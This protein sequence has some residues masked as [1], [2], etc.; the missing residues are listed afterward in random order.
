MYPEVPIALRLSGQ[1][2]LGV[3]RIYS[4]Q[5]D[6]LYHDCNTALAGMSKSYSSVNINLP[7]DAT[8]APYHAVTLPETF[9]LDALELEDDHHYGY[10]D[11]HRK[12]LEDITLEDQIPTGTDPYIVITLN[13]VVRKDSSVLG[14]ALETD[15]VPMEEDSHPSLPLDGTANISPDNQ[16]GAH[17]KTIEVGTSQDLPEIEI[18]RDAAHD[19]QIDSNRTWP[20]QGYDA[21]EPDRVLEELI[22]KD[23]EAISPHAGEILA[24]GQSSVPAHQP[25][26]PSPIPSEHTHESLDLPISLRLNSPELA[27]RSTPPAEQPRAR[28]RRRR[29]QPFDKTTVLSNEF[30]N[31]SRENRSNILRKKRN[32]SST[33]L[34]LM[35]DIRLKRDP[36]FHNPLI[37]GLSSELQSICD[38]QFISS[39]T[40]LLFSD[41]IHQDADVPRSPPLRDNT[42]MEIEHLRNYEVPEMHA[43]GSVIQPSSPPN[44]FNPSP[45]RGDKSTPATF[46]FGSHSGLVETNI[47]SE[48]RPTIDFTPSVGFFSS[49]L[50]TPATY[51]GERFGLENTGLSDIPE[52]PNSAGDL[53][54]LEQD[55]N[56]PAGSQGTPEIARRTGTPRETTAFDALSARTRAVAQYLKRQSST[57]PKADQSSGNL[58]LHSILEHK[59]RKICA[60]MFYETLVLKNCGLVDVHQDEPYDDIKLQ[61]TTKL[62]EEDS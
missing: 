54:F 34:D 6:Y 52:L 51:S 32:R 45:G 8:Q 20:D 53:N 14:D 7:E 24:S 9:S 40:H 12:Q 16:A 21:M 49:D 19:F 58:S 31:A 5:V 46:D 26:V 23:K 13:E 2:L 62:A 30:M 37:T 48:V 22:M 38:P 60:R 33:D 39:K 11:N 41:E 56:T 35:L 28:Q 29:R 18:I 55:D 27:I 44:T 57:T 25:N 47:R 61:L 3:V 1:L 50:E 36:I 59:S 4:K 43:V 42:Q 17:E 15:P 10:E